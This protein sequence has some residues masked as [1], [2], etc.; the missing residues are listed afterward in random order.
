MASSTMALAR[1]FTKRSKRNNEPTTPTRAIGNRRTTIN[2][3]MISL[4]IE[5]ISTTNVHALTAPDI[6]TLNKSGSSTH[7]N[8]SEFS[9]IDTSFL[10]TPLL[11]AD[12]SS[13]DSSPVTPITPDIVDTGNYFDATPKAGSDSIRIAS[14][15]S[16][17]TPAIPQRAPS[18]SKR[19][20]V[21][22]SRKRSIQR[23]SPPPNSLS[24]PTAARDSVDHMNG[25]TS[26]E[27]PFKKELAQVNE[28][29]EEFGLASS[30]LD[31]EE[32][33]MMSKGL[34]KFAVEDYLAE[35]AGLS[36]G[37]FDG[38]LARPWY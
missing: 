16:F 22:L 33:E 7:S 36:G 37:V 35:I 6:A 9:R 12:T 38:K 17:E 31:E 28:V 21:E 14:D 2:R 27:H 32:R 18:H 4:P 5:L 30:M 1:A 34:Q 15:F 19:A 24:Q 10:S 25:T 11:S 20:H 26:P 3:N 29:A 8:D 13:V 23:M